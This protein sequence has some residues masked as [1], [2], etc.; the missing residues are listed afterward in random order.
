MQIYQLGNS[1]LRSSRLVYGCMR[2]TGD[3]SSAALERGKRAV[4]AAIDAGFTVFDHADIY[5]NGDCESLFGEVLRESP[6]LRDRLILQSKCGVVFPTDGVP[7]HYDLSSRHITASVDASLG[8][9]GVEA[10]D[11]F[12]LHRPDFLFAPDEV[13]SAFDALRAAGKVRYFGVSNFSASQV[14]LLTAALGQPPIVN[15]LEVNL[16]TIDALTDGT[17]DQCLQAGIAPQAWSP[18]AGFAFPAWHNR[19]SAEQEARVLK[20]VE[21]QAADYGVEPWLIPVAWLLKHPS[22]M[23]PVIGSTTPAR[24]AAAPAAIDIP[25][26]R[27]DWY[28]LLEARNGAPVP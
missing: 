18:L 23:F 10:I 25:Y 28:R 15:Q 8:R 12:L 16:N 2:L 5:G 27:P 26:S 17:L 9:L 14:S 1:G 20:E 3:G 13:A 24:I 19:F 4:H 11:I 7:A 22:R 6:G 21:R